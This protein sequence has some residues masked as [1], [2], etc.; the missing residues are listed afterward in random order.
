MDDWITKNNLKWLTSN[1]KDEACKLLKRSAGWI[2]ISKELKEIFSNYFKIWNKP[3]FIAQNVITIPIKTPFDEMP[4][5]NKTFKIAYAG[6]MWTMHFDSFLAVAGAVSELRQSGV[7]IELVLYTK[8]DFWNTYLERW[9]KL[10]VSYGGLLPHNELN[11]CLKRYDLL[12]LSSSFLPEYENITR[13]SIQTKLIDYMISGVPIFSC[14][15]LYSACNNL[16]KKW[17]CGLVC[18]TNQIKEIKIILLKQIN[19]KVANRELAKRAYEVAIENFEKTKVC[20]NLYN[21][22]ISTKKVHD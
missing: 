5:P 15:P 14:G 11:D 20:S 22:I 19:N 21:F 9:K 1:I 8:K 13:S 10:E 7:D 2:M 12:L 4:P 18:E 16:I 6:S 17:G 3:Y